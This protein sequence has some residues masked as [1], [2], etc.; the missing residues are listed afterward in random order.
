MERTLFEPEHELFRESYQKFLAQHVA[1][2]HEKWEEQNIVDRDVWVEAGKQGFLGTAVPEEFGG[3]G[4]K[5]F[6]YNAII[7][8]E[9]TKGGFS[10]IGFTLHNDVVAPY[11][12][13]LTNQEQKQRWLPGF[14][15]GEL[16]SAIA[17]TEPG[18]GS[19]LQ[20]IKTKAV[21][22]GDHWVL[23]GSKTF[24]TNGIN[25]DIIIVVACTDP[26]K[27]AQGF[28]LL[29]VERDMP[30]FERGRNLDKI[31]MKAQ[32]T[33]EL[34]FTDVRVPAANLLGE[35]GMGFFYL[36][37]NLPQERLSIAVVAAAAMESVLESTIQYCRDRKAFGKSIG[38]FQN[39]RFVLAELA[40]E[41]TAVRILV[42]KFI[43]QLNAE[44]LTVQEAAMA[45]WWTTEAQ[46]KLIDRCLQLHGGYGYMK[47]Y[48]VAK[49]Y[50]DSRVQTIYGGTTEIMKEIIGRSLNL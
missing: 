12:L 26:D 30:G 2:N 24:I 15:S 38:S 42:D 4:V 23:N 6:R 29:V 27:G 25:A 9:T 37:K 11:L 49:A 43:E 40:T 10:G 22:D 50:M 16:I 19:D 20:G 5:D 47:E 41:T 14:A 34:S 13:E 21:R 46:V 7:T 32:D 1:P 36:M 31:G 3:G 48:P 39:T 33:A 18:T 17:M 28:S 44:K 35:E 45:K 8:E